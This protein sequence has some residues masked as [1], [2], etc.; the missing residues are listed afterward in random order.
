[1]KE[2]IAM[3]ECYDCSEEKQKVLKIY[4]CNSINDVGI[5]FWINNTGKSDTDLTNQYLL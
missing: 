3:L 2:L 1:M 5:L 4:R